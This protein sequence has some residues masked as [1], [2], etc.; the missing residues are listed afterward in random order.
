MSDQGE[1]G[2]APL[3]GDEADLFRE[4]NHR[5]VR[6]VQ[7]R[8]N[9][10]REI[11]DDACGFAWQQFM[12][13]QPD[14]ERNWRAWMVTTAEREAWRLWKIEAD[15][16]SLSLERDG[17]SAACVVPD[18]HDQM[19]IRM[20]LRVALSALAE[21]PARRRDIKALQVTGFSY[22]EIGEMRGLSYTRVNRMVAEANAVLR[23]EQGREAVVHVHASPRAALLFELEDKP[24]KWLQ[25]AIGRRPAL[26]GDPR[27]VLAWR[28]AAL[29]I[30]DYRR[31][32][33]Q[34][35]GDEP[36]GERPRDCEAARAF[37]L[38]DAAIRRAVEAR[39]RER[40]TG[41]ER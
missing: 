9:A 23:E 33:G 8:T 32:H 7:W 12:R 25:S 6:V 37:D 18:R 17:E 40:D 39:G 3:R 36:L 11:V 19:A 26:T 41:R 34:G 28:R 16:L 35:L 27:A 29:A 31:V 15:H 21:V 38:A 10:P 2:H 30:D 4:F 20:R 22:Q 1:G 24:P 13:Y 14:R 5:F